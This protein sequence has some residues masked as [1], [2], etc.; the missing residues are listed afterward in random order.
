MDALFVALDRACPACDSAEGL[1]SEGE[2]CDG[3]GCW[4]LLHSTCW[5]RMD[6]C[7]SCFGVSDGPR[8]VRVLGGRPAKSCGYCH[9][10]ELERA[11]SC[12]GCQ[13]V[14]HDA[15]WLEADRCPT[16]GCTYVVSLR[17]ASAAIRSWTAPRPDPTARLTPEVLAFVALYPGGLG[18]ILFEACQPGIRF[19]GPN[20]GIYFLASAVLGW[21]LWF[22]ASWVAVG[23]YRAVRARR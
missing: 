19:A 16:P 15:C 17:R 5:A 3:P 4:A 7:P 21:L 23:L 1:F 10:D 20:M 8:E 2:L 9:A 14:L 22:V 18:G 12:P 13:I 11:R 6:G